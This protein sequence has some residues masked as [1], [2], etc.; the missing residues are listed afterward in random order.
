MSNSIISGKDLLNLPS[1]KSGEGLKQVADHARAD[2]SAK[3]VSNCQTVPRGSLPDYAASLPHA[4]ILEPSNPAPG[5]EGRVP[6]D[7]GVDYHSLS[8]TFLR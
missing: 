5:D 7:L 8:Q 6:F 4:M 3:T 2:A 1:T